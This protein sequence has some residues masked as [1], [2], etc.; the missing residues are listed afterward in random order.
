MCAQS[1][2]ADVDATQGGKLMEGPNDK[3]KMMDRL[4]MYVFNICREK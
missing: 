3:V 2:K 4:V 1:I